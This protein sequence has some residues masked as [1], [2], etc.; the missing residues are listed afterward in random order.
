MGSPASKLNPVSA[1]DDVAEDD[2]E[3][4]EEEDE[5]DNEDVEAEEEDEDKV[6]EQTAKEEATE[7]ALSADEEDLSAK[8]E[9]GVARF[10]ALSSTNPACV[11][12]RLVAGAGLDAAAFF[13]ALVAGTIALAATDLRVLALASGAVVSVPI[14]DPATA[15]KAEPP[16][17]CEFC[18]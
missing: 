6:E 18:L 10:A 17:N 7:E 16:R 15:V 1:A 11:T 5:E 8:D 12:V 9:P 14:G 3:G 2:A 4:A 13:S